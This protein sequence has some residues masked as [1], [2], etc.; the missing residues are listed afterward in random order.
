MVMETR[1]MNRCPLLVASLLMSI[2]LWQ[3]RS[4]PDLQ[5]REVSTLAIGSKA[6]DFKLQGVDDISTPLPKGTLY[7]GENP[8]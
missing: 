4:A 5:A 7:P 8:F 6:P 1:L 2:A 3:V